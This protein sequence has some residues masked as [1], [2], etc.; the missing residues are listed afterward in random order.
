MDPVE[1][2]PYEV[3]V[4]IISYASSR[5][6]SGPLPLILVS[7]QWESVIVET[8]ELWTYIVINNDEDTL[9]RITTSL[10]LSHQK[11]LDVQIISPLKY[12]VLISFLMRDEVA[13]RIRS[14]EFP[15]PEVYPSAV[16]DE[17][18][19]TILE[20]LLPRNIT[21]PILERIS[22][23][24]QTSLVADFLKACPRLRSISGVT[25]SK[26]TLPYLS[27]EAESIEYISAALDDTR[28]LSDRKLT[29]LTLR[30]AQ[31]RWRLNFNRTIS[32]DVVSMAFPNLLHLDLRTYGYNYYIKSVF[33]QPLTQL[34]TFSTSI[35]KQA[36]HF[37]ANSL[38]TLPALT[39]LSIRIIEAPSDLVWRPAAALARAEGP[40]LKRFT[41]RDGTRL[42]NPNP[43]F[44]IFV[45]S[46][47]GKQYLQTVEEFFIF[48]TG[49]TY[50]R[51]SQLLPMLGDMPSLRKL[52]IDASLEHSRPE[53]SVKLTMAAP[54]FPA[55]ITMSN[56]EDLT[57]THGDGI[58]F[59]Y[60]PRLCNL[61]ITEAPLIVKE[62]PK[63]AGFGHTL[64][65]LSV[66]PANFDMM[67]TLHSTKVINEKD[68]ITYKWKALTEITW[69]SWEKACAH[70]TASF[71]SLTTVSLS[72]NNDP[73]VLK[74][75]PFNSLC[76][77]L[78]EIKSACPSLRTINS[79]V[80][81][82]WSLLLAMLKQ[83]KTEPN[84]KPII[85]IGLPALPAV[86]ILSLLVDSLRERE[87]GEKDPGHVDSGRV[88][89]GYIARDIDSFIRV[90][91]KKL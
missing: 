51:F 35:P 46:F 27:E 73:K 76:R 85:T 48:L 32:P 66:T 2:F 19:T 88:R 3:F 71:P 12:P 4:S 54:S 91:L 22:S 82:H 72:C 40:K 41:V 20:Y 57:I 58:R 84:V 34:E 42:S 87:N 37:F 49:S 8:P 17:V 55:P 26:A 15:K 68:D 47:T 24:Y 50:Y 11:P 28:S 13:S 79:R 25:V 43:G 38:Y 33:A 69:T 45:T 56:L 59:I 1:V 5:D 86:P 21:F 6:P 62:I 63:E 64:T 67:N 30:N 29:M 16:R 77:A 74:D 80:Y 83:R 81:P 60:A 39:N 89:A 61:R 78:L 70:H 90:R 7:A 52:R 44:P 14:L 31:D 75:N 10:H 18:I 9:H 53:R 36:V 23:G 65:K